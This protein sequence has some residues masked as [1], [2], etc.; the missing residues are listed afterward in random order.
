MISFHWSNN[1][2]HADLIE[3]QSPYLGVPGEVCAGGDGVFWL[4]GKCVPEGI[5]DPPMPWLL[6]YLIPALAILVLIVLVRDSIKKGELTWW[7]LMC[8]ASASTFWLETFGDWGQHLLYSPNF[9]HYALDLPF[10]APHNPAWMPFMYAV[11]WVLH[12]WAILELAKFYQRRH[13][14][15]SLGKAIIVFTVPLTFVWNIAV[16][17]TAAYMGWWTYDPPIGPYLDMGRGNFPLMW[18]MLTMFIW[19]NLI[20]WLV[21]A[22]EESGPNRL[23]RLC[24]LSQSFKFDNNDS[25]LALGTT[26]SAPLMRLAAW[27]AIFNVTFIICLIVP[28]LGLRLLTGWDSLYL[29]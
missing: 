16:E 27:V 18:P 29:P 22:P 10:T 25:S 8:I 4:D 9:H 13:P 2:A 17:G 1:N 12:T 19:P 14:G 21:G 11:Y 7:V 26:A 24:G 20:S 5:V 23:E 15:A 6:N 28:L 3:K